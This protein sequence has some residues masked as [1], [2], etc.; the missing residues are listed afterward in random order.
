M[1]IL[2]LSQ[3]VAPIRFAG[4]FGRDLRR[5]LFSRLVDRLYR[6]RAPRCPRLDLETMPAYLQRDIG[7]IDW[8]LPSGC[9]TGRQAQWP[10]AP[11]T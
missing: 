8:R 2:N 6:T 5:S 11:W 3:N 10:A 9:E 7:I 1:A 4:P